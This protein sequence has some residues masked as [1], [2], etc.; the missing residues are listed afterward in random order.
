MVPVDVVNACIDLAAKAATITLTPDQ[1]PQVIRKKIGPL[2]T[3][4][5]PYGQTTTEFTAVDLLLAPYLRGD[6][7]QAIL[8]RS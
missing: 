5:A 8:E 7:N 3:E 6:G 2:E 1:G 4:Y